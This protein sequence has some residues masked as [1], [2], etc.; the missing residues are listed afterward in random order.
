MAPCALSHLNF[1]FFG[2]LF[3]FVG[4]GFGG[5]DHRQAAINHGNH[6][7]TILWRRRLLLL[8]LGRVVGGLS[9]G[10]G[11]RLRLLLG[12]VGGRRRDGHSILVWLHG[13]VR[14]RFGRFER[15]VGDGGG[16]SGRGAG[17]AAQQ[18]LELLALGWG[19]FA[20]AHWIR[21]AAELAAHAVA[22]R[23][24]VHRPLGRVLVD[25]I[26]EAAV[27]ALH[28]ALPVQRVVRLVRELV[29]LAVEG[30]DVARVRAV[31]DAAG[32]ADLVLAA[33]G[34]RNRAVRS[35]GGPLLERVGRRRVLLLA[36]QL[37]VGGRGGR[38]RCDLFR[39]RQWIHGRLV[40]V[41]FTGF[42]G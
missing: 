12:G 4:N 22:A 21:G 25:Q 1:I 31:V 24:V 40:L 19:R 20:L 32:P 23:V 41:A 37:L 18:T 17:P 34:V 10:C 8:W 6:H 11:R 15:R 13:T 27:G 33:R 42:A 16:G 14:G 5:R 26:L 9:E 28:E 39:L 29:V 35:N 30:L 7:F 2:I 38:W 36:F 3:V